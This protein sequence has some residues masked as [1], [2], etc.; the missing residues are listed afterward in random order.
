MEQILQIAQ[1][2]LHQR[3]HGRPFCILCTWYKCGDWLLLKWVQHH[4]LMVDPFT[5]D[6]KIPWG[7]HPFSWCTLSQEMPL[8]T[9]YFFLFKVN[10]PIQ[11]QHRMRRQFSPTQYVVVQFTRLILSCFV[12]LWGFLYLLILN[13]TLPLVSCVESIPTLDKQTNVDDFLTGCTVVIVFNFQSLFCFS[14]QPV[15]PVKLH[16]THGK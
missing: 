15:I 11:S 14:I 7:G 13:F 9:A 10:L 1:C 3:P 4:L 16:R 8:I 5:G 6:C 12:L 2:Y